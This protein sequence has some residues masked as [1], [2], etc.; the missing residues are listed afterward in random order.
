M[1]EF[2][3]EY[4]IIEELGWEVIKVGDMY[5]AKDYWEV[6]QIRNELFS[7]DIVQ[8]K[9]YTL[10][11]PNEVTNNSRV[12]CQ[13]SGQTIGDKVCQQIPGVS[14]QYYLTNPV[15][16]D[17][18]D[19]E[20]APEGSFNY[21]SSYDCVT[22][23]DGNC[24]GPGGKYCTPPETAPAAPEPTSDPINDRRTYSYSLDQYGERP[25][26][27]DNED[28][29]TTD[30]STTISDDIKTLVG[31]NI[32]SET[33]SDPW[34]QTGYESYLQSSEERNSLIDA[35][36]E[37]FTK[38]EKIVIGVGQ[39]VDM[40]NNSDAR[41]AVLD[42]LF[43]GPNRMMIESDKE[44]PLQI[45]GPYQDKFSSE[46]V[47]NESRQGDG[48]DEENLVQPKVLVINFPTD[49]TLRQFSPLTQIDTMYGGSAATNAMFNNGNVFRET[50][51]NPKTDRWNNPVD[52]NDQLIESLADA[53]YGN[54]QVDVVDVIERLEMTQN[55]LD[56]RSEF[57]GP[58]NQDYYDNK[59]VRY[60]YDLLLKDTVEVDGVTSSIQEH[61]DEGRLDEVWLWAAPYAGFMEH[62][63]TVDFSKPT[64][65][66]FN[67][68]REYDQALHS[69]GHRVESRLNYFVPDDFT[70]WTGKGSITDGEYRHV[71]NDQRSIADSLEIKDELMYM[72]NTVGWMRSSGYGNVHFPP[73]AVQ[74]YEYDSELVVDI[75]GFSP[76]DCEVWECDHGQYL[77]WWMQQ[78]DSD[79]Y[80]Y[81]FR[82]DE[83]N[84]KDDIFEI[85]N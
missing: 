13:S 32:D 76:H 24:G 66:G 63:Y 82:R 35:Q 60:D 43:L 65:M 81:S 42:L 70:I 2:E 4:M 46:D 85:F 40:W 51:N 17:P 61:Y 7:E 68:E 6:Y 54:I 73:N 8:E 3:G 11:N 49:T 12:G 55:V 28:E 78:M 69:I 31:T 80:E 29:D 72:Y 67:Y 53:T 57:V 23:C 52:L 19:E 20:V 1:G 34:T 58:Y 27:L 64:V 44:I 15:S 37:K 74:H 25:E 59:I 48:N 62:K 45:G 38:L 22:K 83:R 56:S 77:E 14:G 10:I 41:Q 39:A 30:V 71:G 84:I 33:Y 79:W 50:V 9:G 16:D 5:Y 47:L 36:E 26:G 21:G 18:K 75:P